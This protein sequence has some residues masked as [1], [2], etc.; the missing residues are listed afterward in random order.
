M[1][2]GIDYAHLDAT[3]MLD[4]AIGLE[5]DEHL[6]YREFAGCVRDQAT[7][8]FFQELGENEAQHLRRLESRRDLLVRHGPAQSV[9][10]AQPRNMAKDMLAA[11]NAIRERLGLKP[12]EWSDTLADWAYDW[13]FTL[14]T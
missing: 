3:S 2:L 6:R 1:A 11:H 14:A 5:E 9:R 12:L 4:F 13:A 7:A 8:R 10:R